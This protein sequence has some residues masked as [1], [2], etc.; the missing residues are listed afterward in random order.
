MWL[1]FIKKL[2][3]KNVSY[4][5][6]SFMQSFSAFLPNLNIYLG[7]IKMI[8]FYDRSSSSICAMMFRLPKTE[9]MVIIISFSL[10]F[11]CMVDIKMYS[12]PKVIEIFKQIIFLFKL[13]SKTSNHFSTI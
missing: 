7:A 1:A 2:F 3:Y 12:E 8:S 5:Y 6:F 13:S 11:P 4:I 9:R 10:T